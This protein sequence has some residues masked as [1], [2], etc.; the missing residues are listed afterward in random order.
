MTY[1]PRNFGQVT[2][3]RPVTWPI[4]TTRGPKKIVPYGEWCQREAKKIG[5]HVRVG[6][7]NGV[8]MVSIFEGIE[9]RA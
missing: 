6:D 4:N 9:K 3:W 5:G 8:T 7:V 2:H 1:N